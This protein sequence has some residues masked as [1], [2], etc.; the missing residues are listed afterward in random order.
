MLLDMEQLRYFLVR[1][2]LEDIQ[3]EHGTASVG[4]LRHKCHQHF[5]RQVAPAFGNTC[6]VLHIGKLFFVYHQLAETVLPP[7]I[8]DGLRHHDPRHPCAQRTFATKR[9]TGEDFDKAVMQNIVRRIHIARITV[10]HRQHLFG[11]ESVKFLS[12]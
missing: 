8:V 1:L 9:E 7:Q 3:V 10:A 6:F 4:K 2:F 12:G 5:F 11:I